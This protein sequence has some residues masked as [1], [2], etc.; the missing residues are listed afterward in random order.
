LIRTI[1]DESHIWAGMWRTQVR[2]GMIPYYMFVEP[3]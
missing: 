2:M 1:N 3:A